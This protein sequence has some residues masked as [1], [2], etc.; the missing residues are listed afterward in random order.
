MDPRAAHEREAASDPRLVRRIRAEIEAAGRI[1]FARFMEL[2]LYD[3]EAGYYTTSAERGTR[4]GDFLT[5]PE[6]H[7]IFGRALARQLE[8][9]WERLDRPDPFTLREYGA[10]SGALA[11]AVLDGLRAAG[12]G[13]FEALRYEPREIS[14][15]R[16]ERIRL[17]LAETGLADHLV[18]HSGSAGAPGPA[19][20]P[21]LVGCVLAN[22]FLDALPVH[23]LVVR[24]G[25]LREIHTVWRDGWFGDEEGPPAD[26]ARIEPLLEGAPPLAEGQRLEVAPATREWVTE[27]AAELGRGVV[28]VIDYGASAA[29]LYGPRRRAGSLLAYRGHRVSEDPY[30]ALGRQDL[31]AHVDFSMLEAA[32]RESDLVVLGR[33]TQAEFLAG[34]DLGGLLLEEQQAARDLATYLAARAAARRLLDPAATGRFGVL[35]LGREV[36]PEPPLHGLSFRVSEALDPRPVG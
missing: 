5:A 8:E 36:A 32:A 20:E 30:D 16:I 13:L 12:S 3:A 25:Q 28:L 15:A 18:Q 33:T 35:L 2:C 7:P 19:S 27:V 31:T 22:E 26:R 34:L 9:L 6:M 17:R 29:D 11:A 23:R 24:S 4:E 14:P 21:L 1:T 10:G